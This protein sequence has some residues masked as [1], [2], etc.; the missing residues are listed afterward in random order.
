MQ[1]QQIQN[2]SYNENDKSPVTAELLIATSYFFYIFKI[3]MKDRRGSH[4]VRY[5]FLNDTL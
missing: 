5:I 1:L 4:F 2:F 3:S